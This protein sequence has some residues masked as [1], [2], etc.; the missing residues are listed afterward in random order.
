MTITGEGPVGSTIAL[1]AV[2]AVVIST[3]GIEDRAASLDASS[4]LLDT[5]PEL[6]SMAV[7][8]L[9]YALEE[10]FD[11]TVD[12]EDVTA[13]AFETLT[14]LTEFVARQRD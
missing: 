12:G 9:V 4:P 13:E 8:E 2:K 10:R 11:I 1:D 6:D 7:L 5:L 3:L 14:T